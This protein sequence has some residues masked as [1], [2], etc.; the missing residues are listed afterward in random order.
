MLSSMFKKWIVIK[1][2]KHLP[3]AASEYKTHLSTIFWDEIINFYASNAIH[4]P[5]DEITAGDI[6]LENGHFFLK[7]KNGEKFKL[8]SLDNLQ[9]IKIMWICAENGEK[10]TKLETEVGK[11]K[12]EVGELKDLLVCMITY[13]KEIKG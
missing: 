1:H 5:I 2:A 4:V 10:L 7:I 13:F 11:L 12:N 6:V 8:T 9:D 3:S